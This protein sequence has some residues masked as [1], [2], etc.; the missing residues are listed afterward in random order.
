MMMI[1]IIISVII[2]TPSLLSLPRT[3][4]SAFLERDEQT[5]G[6]NVGGVD[7]LR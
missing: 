1:V 7:S 4:K 5:M 6:M 2:S 3:Q